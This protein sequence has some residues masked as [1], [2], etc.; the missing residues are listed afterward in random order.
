MI[1]NEL[2]VHWHVDP[3]ILHIGG[4]ELRWYSILFVSGF[5][6]GWFIFS[7]FF[8]REKVDK[9]LLDPLLYTLLICTI[10]GARLG[11]CLFYQPDYY[12]GSWEG[13]WEIFMPWKGGLA[14]HG[15]TIAL[16]LGMWWFARRYGKKNG[17]DFVWLLDHL[18]IAVAF[19]GAF[20]RFGNLFN[21]EI[22]GNVTDLPWGFIFEL[23]GETEPKHPTQLYEGFTYLLLGFALIGLYKWR[24]DKMY[25]G[26]F[27][28][29]FLLVCFGSRFLIEFIKEP[30]VEF[31]KAMALNM[32]QLL[33]IPFI[34]LGVF[35]LVWAFTKKVPARA[36]HP[37]PVKAKKE[38]T[39]YAK[40]VGK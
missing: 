33:S 21:S 17:F 28:G 31:E 6:L 16:I 12:L 15:G 25:R 23:R 26:E 39:H 37:E 3:A 40:P 7:W 35:F 13:F 38:A 27:I 9:K 20:I 19:A 36:V 8:T 30:Q 2:V 10:V 34:L 1:M 14:S 5:I 4:F 29:I 18:A 24:L 11:H 32:G 22:Y